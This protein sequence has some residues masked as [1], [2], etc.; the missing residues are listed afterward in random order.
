MDFNDNVPGK[1]N[2]LRDI[3]KREV[4]EKPDPR[5]D[6]ADKP[7]MRHGGGKFY[8][9]HALVPDDGARYLNA[10]FF[11]DDIFIADAAVFSAVTL[12]V[13]CRTENA[14]VKKSAP[15]RAA[16]AIVDGF[17]LGNLAKRPLADIV[18]R[19]KSQRNGVK[20]S[21]IGDFHEVRG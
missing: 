6:S 3:R 10:A 2:N 21:C 7:N 9:P 12:K 18:R 19:G 1:I 17:R 5:R 4:K 14:L 16:R 20:I 11:A 15:L 13:L 8:V